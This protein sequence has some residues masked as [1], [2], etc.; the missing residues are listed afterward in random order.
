MPEQRPRVAVCVAGQLRSAGCAGSAGARLTPVESIDT[1]LLAVLRQRY[2]VSIFAALDAPPRRGQRLPGALGNHLARALSVL[3]PDQ[4]ALFGEADDE[5]AWSVSRAPVA[6]R[7]GEA[8][9]SRNGSACARLSHRLEHLY[10]AAAYSQARK[11]Q[12]CW[13]MLLAREASV[14]LR[15]D[16]VV[17]LRP[18]VV[19][20]RPFE[21]WK[22]M[23]R[24]A[25]SRHTGRHAIDPG[26][27]P[28]AQ[29]KEGASKEE[30]RNAAREAWAP[31]RDLCVRRRVGGGDASSASPGVCYAPCDPSPPP[32]PAS[33]GLYQGLYPLLVDGSAS[34]RSRGS[35]DAATATDAGADGRPPSQH[36]SQ[37]PSQPHVD[38]LTTSPF[39]GMMTA[40]YFNDHFYVATRRV[41]RPFLDQLS[42]VDDA[43]LRPVSD[44]ARHWEALERRSARAP[45]TKSGKLASKSGP[46]I[47][48]AFCERV[49]QIV[50]SAPIPSPCAAY[51]TR[52]VADGQQPW[53]CRDGSMHEC[54]IALGLSAHGPTCCDQLRV[55]YVTRPDTPRLLRLDDAP[56]SD[57]DLPREAYYCSERLGVRSTRGPALA[58]P[59]GERKLNASAKEGMRCPEW[60]PFA[61]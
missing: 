22:Y 14:G 15:Y 23:G 47:R 16:Y 55:R 59:R 7:L 6:S 38:L 44:K 24:E 54:T 35:D 26:F 12:A 19:F 29:P 36:P 2:D 13:S 61:G 52:L 20:E 9:S 21:L 50:D 39:T 37:Q 10:G 30:V 58:R 46:A 11:L 4:L 33:A 42:L 40:V 18:D 49:L 25:S 53:A 56:G 41:A 34:A 60:N 27:A 28:P 43:V 8:G 17:R 3:K 1:H 32:V 48:A 51:A 45:P 31:L 5:A 57:C